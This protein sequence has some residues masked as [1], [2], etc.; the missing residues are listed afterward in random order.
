MNF[1][2]INL[3]SIGQGTPLVFFH[4]WGF[5][6]QI[7][8][9]LQPHL[10][11]HYTM[12]L[13]DLPGFGHTPPM[14]WD[15]FK[16]LLL[17]Q[18]PA[19]FALFGWSLGGLYATRLAI[20]APERVTALLNSS[21]SPRFTNDEGWPAVSKEVFNNFYEQLSV[22]PRSTLNDFVALQSQRS[23]AII[24]EGQ[25]PSYAGLASGLDILGSWDFRD[26]IR[27]LKLPVGFMFGRLDPITPVKLMECM[28]LNYP[29]FHYVLFKKAAHMPFI[30]HKDDFIAELTSFIS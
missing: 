27:A 21:T 30:S 22:N 24:P 1:M 13:V 9:P 12:I 4:G 15:D 25:E 5:D 23:Q 2:K 8:L 14:A 29:H 20:E 10:Q 11:H 17:A 26:S 18:L 6:H 19:R 16:R 28:K 3:V 7:W